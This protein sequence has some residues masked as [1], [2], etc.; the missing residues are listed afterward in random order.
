MIVAPHPGTVPETQAAMKRLDRHVASLL[1]RLDD[2]AHQ[3][4]EDVVG[5]VDLTETFA[6]CGDRSPFGLPAGE[7]VGVRGEALQAKGNLTSARL[8]RFVFP[9]F[10]INAIL[11]LI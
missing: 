1:A 8:T 5:L 10:R 7:S 4:D 11:L 3:L 2:V 6:G 9:F